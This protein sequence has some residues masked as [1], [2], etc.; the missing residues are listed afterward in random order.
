MTGRW[1]TARVSNREQVAQTGRLGVLLVSLLALLVVSPGL[2]TAADGPIDGAPS[3]GDPYRPREGNA[4][5]DVAHYDLDLRVEPRRRTIHGTA[6]ITL[7]PTVDLRSFTFDFA[8]F[9]VSTVT[10]DGAAAQVERPDRKLRVI[11]AAPLPAGDSVVVRVTYAGEPRTTGRTGWLWFRHGGALV[12]TQTNGASTLF[13]CNDH[14]SDKATFA[15]T[16]TTPRRSVGIANGLLQQ[17]SRPN[18]HSVRF[19]WSEPEPFPTYAAVV[20]VGRFRLA[21]NEGPGGLP[22]INGFPARDALQAKAPK[23][24]PKDAK[25]RKRQKKRLRKRQKKALR[26]VRRKVDHQGGIVAVL[27]QYFGPYSYS[28]IGAIIVPIGVEGPQAI[29]AATRPTYP[30]VRK[31]LKDDDFAQLV[32]H[33]IAHQWFGNAVSLTTWR[34]MWLNEGFATYGELLWIAEQR[35]VPIGSLFARGSNVFGY[36]PDMERPA[37]DPGADHLFSVTVYNRG[38]LTLEALRRTVGDD[39]F[40]QILRDYYADFR[41]GN[42]TT[43]GFIDV[44]EDVS[45]QDLDAFFQRWLYEP[46]LPELPPAP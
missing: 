1:G 7:T 39:A 9:T 45:G 21:Q 31:V 11:P 6:I 28:S 16:V 42:A 34:D 40:Y 15:F 29:E 43:E 22:I 36:Y 33:E 17:Q 4:G 26:R 5:Y 2:L 3:I 25:E 24:K 18:R 20:A 27:E 46:G 14:P 37:G 35:G 32:A 41:G 8:G 13:P 10:V 12:S 19:E 30:G 38:A 23:G 44:A